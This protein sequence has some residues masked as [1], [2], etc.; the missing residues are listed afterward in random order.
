MTGCLSV[1]FALFDCLWAHYNI[2]SQNVIEILRVGLAVFLQNCSDFA[3]Q[4]YLLLLT[5]L[6]TL[7]H[8]PVSWSNYNILSNISNW[9]MR[10]Y[11]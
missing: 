9:S 4:S 10:Q 3:E 7:I 8:I 5:V 11:G 6:T 1:L 2:L